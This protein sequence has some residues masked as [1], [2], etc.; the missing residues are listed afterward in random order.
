MHQ[1]PFG[2][3]SPK[4][5]RWRHVHFTRMQYQCEHQAEMTEKRRD[6]TPN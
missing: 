3:N 4:R 6:K 1:C 5:K 2:R